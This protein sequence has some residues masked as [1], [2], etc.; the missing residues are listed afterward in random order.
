MQTGKWSYLPSVI[1]SGEKENSWLLVGRRI[2]P[3]LPS[4]VK[5][6]DALPSGEG[7]RR[8]AYFYQQTLGNTDWQRAAFIGDI[9]MLS[10]F[11]VRFLSSSSSFTV[12]KHWKN[13]APSSPYSS[14]TFT[15]CLSSFPL[16]S[17]G[18]EKK[19]KELLSLEEVQKILNDV[20]ADDVKVIPAPSGCEFTD[21]MV[22]AT[23]RSPWHVR[24]ICEALVYKV[25]EKQKGAKRMILPAVV[26]REGGK[27]AV[28]DSGTLIV[29]AVDEKARAY[30]N[31][32]GLWSSD[33]P[34]NENTQDLENAFVKVRRKNNSK[35]PSQA[36]A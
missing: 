29:H 31:F 30:Y 13:L 36:R 17:D 14:S 34:D 8:F 20:L 25:K 4:G 26:G 6:C 12:T 23:G 28:I 3:A 16:N 27:W 19:K 35:K 18:I 5:I 10:A 22:V 15:R 11:R 21:Y 9:I 24:N 1:F 7:W 32:E 2:C 33:T